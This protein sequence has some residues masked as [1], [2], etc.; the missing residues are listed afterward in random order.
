MSEQLSAEEDELTEPE[1]G[2]H[3]LWLQKPTILRAD[4]DVNKQGPMI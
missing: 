2:P 3:Q 4:T 1:S